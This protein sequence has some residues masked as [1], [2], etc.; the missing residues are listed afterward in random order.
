MQN[1]VEFLV[2]FLHR[3]ASATTTLADA[4]YLRN[5]LILWFSVIL[6]RGAALGYENADDDQRLLDALEEM[7]L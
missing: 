7:R 4:E 2:A 3:I 5:R 1:D 6:A